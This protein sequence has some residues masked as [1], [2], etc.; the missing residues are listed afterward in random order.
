MITVDDGYLDFYE[1]AYP[2]LKALNLPATFFVTAHFVDQQIWLWPDRVEYALNHTT[3]TETT[4]Q[5]GSA[6]YPVSLGSARERFNAW[7]MVSDYCITAQDDEKWNIIHRL[8]KQLE[9][10]LPEKPPEDY[11]AVTWDQLAE[12]ARNNIDIGSHTLRHPILSRIDPGTLIAEVG[13]SKKQIE[14]AL[15]QQVFTFC[16][17]NSAPGDIN[18]QVIAQVKAAG[19]SGAVFGINLNKWE[20]YQIPR[21]AADNDMQS[22]RMKMAGMEILSQKMNNN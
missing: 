15:N 11:A 19:Y 16:Y 22:F 1:Q 13:E 21:I 8:E 6:R 14:T 12:M 3:L 20:P 9:V 5:L 2:E 4:I 7:K 10:T 17:P 18:D